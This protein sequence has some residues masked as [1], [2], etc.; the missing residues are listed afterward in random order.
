ME[1]PGKYPR[2]EFLKY[3]LMSAGGLT[4]AACGG[5]NEKQPDQ[6]N[7]APVK[8][9]ANTSPQKEQYV[10]NKNITWLKK[11]AEKYDELRLGHN[12]RFNKFPAA[13][14]FCHTADGVQEAV[15]TARKNK[16]PVAIKSGGHSLEGFSGN[17]GGIVINLSEFTKIE[18]EEDSALLGPAC[19][20]TDLYATL[21]P[22]G[23]IIPGGSCGGVAIGGLT[24]GGGYGMFARKFGLTCDSLLEVEMVNG[25]GEKIN[26]KDD[27]ELL[28]ACKGGGSGN[29]G[30]ITQMKFKLH[31][32]P[33]TLTS[34]RFR[35]FNTSPEEA[36]ALTEK[37]FAATQDLPQSCFSV[38]VINGKTVFI[39]LT[40]FGEEDEKVKGVIDTFSSMTEKVSL[41]TAKRTEMAVQSFYGVQKPVFAK[42]SSVGL[43]KDFAEIKDFITEVLAKIAATPGMLLSIG[44]LGGK[45][46]DPELEKESSFAHRGSPYLSELQ[47]YWS[48]EKDGER[49][50][51]AYKEARD[52]FLTNGVD[53][54]YINYPDLGFPDWEKAYYG[55]N[56]QRLQ[57]VK[58]KY[59]PENVFRYEQSILPA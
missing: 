21:I 14:A 39:L 47:T 31:E 38:I 24:L 17:D 26:S 22:K 11:G 55:T 35:K 23:K 48:K 45:I 13:I 34:H 6:K 15:A 10:S 40:N 51:T 8:D 27:P 37:W 44:T 53:K 12:K 3:L 54:Q 4:L 5:E 58:E 32:A 59:D 30:V 29:F 33:S 43:Y 46:S 7:D 49:M 16:L 28:W 42:N 52:I 25:K 36:G 56:Y 57:K 20:L 41:G 19:K 18:Q 9:S 50:I 1:S 2:R